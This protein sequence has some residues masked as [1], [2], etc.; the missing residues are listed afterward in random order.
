[1]PLKVIDVPYIQECINF[2]VKICNKTCNFVSL[3]RSPSQT[4]DEF[5]NFIKNLEINLEHIAN[6]RPF[7]LGDFNTRMQGRYQNNITTFEGCKIN[8]ATSQFGL[9][10]IVK[11]LTHILSNSAS[12]IDLIFISQPY[13]STLV[14]N[15]AVHLPL[16][17]NCH[18]QIIISKFNFTI[19]CPPPYKGLV[20]TISNRIHILLNEQL[21]LIGKI[22]F[23][24]LT[25]IN[26]FLFSKKRLW[27]SFQILF[28]T[29]QS[30]LM[31]KILPG[32]INKLKHLLWKKNG[33][34]KRLK[35][36]LVNSKLL[37]KLA[38]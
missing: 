33:I 21:N 35:Q 23:R 18:H 24:I 17:W 29:K 15:P 25:R 6:K 27:I 16:Y 2:E 7:L 28:R 9:S 10:Q 22:I 26:R 38:S 31:T 1:M 3:Y 36:R 32:W 34:Y 12:C 30:P 8:V 37:E 14:M 4:K 11:E 19:F 13:I 5:E 20:Y